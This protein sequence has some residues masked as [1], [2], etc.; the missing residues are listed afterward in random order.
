VKLGFRG[1]IWNAKELEIRRG[2]KVGKLKRQ[3]VIELFI[4]KFYLSQPHFEESVRMRLTLPEW[5][6][7][8]PSRLPKLQSS[9]IG[10][11]TPRIVA[12]FI[13]LESY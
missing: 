4:K 12:S 1:R 6:L 7:G 2:S 8:S 3:S 10:V 9:I 13:S 5:G 11:K